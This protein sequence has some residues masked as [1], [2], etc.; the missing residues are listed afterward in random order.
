[1]SPTAWPRWLGLS[2]AVHAI[3]IGSVWMSLRTTWQSTSPAPPA[4]VMSVTLVDLR[5]GDST[6]QTVSPPAQPPIAPEEARVDA[7]PPDPRPAAIPEP[8]PAQLN[9]PASP[10]EPPS[11]VQTPLEPPPDAGTSTV[12]SDAPSP[13]VFH[14]DAPAAQAVA[15]AQY[16]PLVLAILE[17]AKRYPLSAQRRGLEGTVEIGFLIGADGEV[18]D[19]RVLV[20][21]SYHALDQA[22]LDMV[23][24]IGSLPAPPERTPLRFPVR[25]EYKLDSIA[26]PISTEG[27]HP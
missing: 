27:A 4:L 5:N 23:H 24:R 13:P 7:V 22:T 18:S 12:P 21:S 6:V 11:Q 14:P 10:E 20:S 8:D 9:Q 16:R 26:S 19:P 2:I 15:R 1:M 25:I 17:R 3:L